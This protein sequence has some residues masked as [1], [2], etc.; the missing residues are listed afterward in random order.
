MQR[1]HKSY[2]NH[3][4]LVGT[5]VILLQSDIL[6]FR[7]IA[8]RMSID[9]VTVDMRVTNAVDHQGSVIKAE[10]IW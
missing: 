10:Y 1:Y 5:F 3:M 4:I 8:W 9:S 6:C 2:D 7:T